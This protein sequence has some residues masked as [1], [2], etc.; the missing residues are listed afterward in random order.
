VRR[1]PLLPLLRCKASTDVLSRPFVSPCASMRTT[2]SDTLLR[3]KTLGVRRVRSSVPAAFAPVSPPKDDALEP[4]SPEC[5]GETFDSDFVLW[6]EED[7]GGDGEGKRRICVDSMLCK[8]LREHQ[9]EGVQ[10][11]FGCVMGFREFQGSGCILADDMGLGKTLQA[12]TLLWTLLTQGTTEQ[13]VCRRG[14]VVCPTSLVTNWANEFNK[15]LHGRMNVLACN[16]STKDKVTYTIDSY[17]RS[18]LP[19]LVLI[20]SYDTFRLYVDRFQKA[21]PSKAPDILICDE[22]HRLKNADTATTQALASLVTRRR[23][24][25]SGTPMQN[26]LEEFYAMVDFTNPGVLG[27][28]SSF[29]RTYMHPILTGREPDASDKEKGLA[30]VRA[31]ELS[32]LVNE[33]ILR[34]TNALLSAHLPPKLVQIVFCRLTELQV[35]G[36]GFGVWGLGFGVWV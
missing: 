9:R 5:A 31:G 14:L 10:F 6:E 36:L 29:R 21:A 12:V 16:E 25:L 1:L 7:A 27:T 30:D 22:A 34:R 26:D 13:S 32:A 2:V 35:Q 4:K 11:M 23:V 8:H 17:L 33:F 15:W 24:L 19:H 3:T 18:S 28:P 20:I